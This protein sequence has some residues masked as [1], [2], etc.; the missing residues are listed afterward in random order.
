MQLYAAKRKGNLEL[1][2][3]Y[4][5]SKTLTDTSGNG[6]GIDVGEDP[7]NRHSN[8]GPASFDRRQIFVTTYDYRLPFFSNLKSVEGAILSGWEVSGITRYQSG[9]PFT[10]T[11]NTAI[12]TRRADYLGGEVLLPIRDRMVGLIR[13]PSDP[14]LSR[15]PGNSGVG[16]VTGPYLVAWDFLHGSSS[17]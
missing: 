10:I 12:G 2:V 17:T 5:W 7:F 15:R 1:T 8:Y 4:T 3:S 14:R 9:A 13:L 11:A 16:I 6:D